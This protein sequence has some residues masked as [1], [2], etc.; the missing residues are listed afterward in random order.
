MKTKRFFQQGCLLF[1]LAFLP[2]EIDA[3]QLHRYVVEVTTS[4]RYHGRL[5]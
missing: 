3:Q 5:K 2:I 4:F 1:F